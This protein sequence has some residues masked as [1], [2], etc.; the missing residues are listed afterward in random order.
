MANQHAQ[1]PEKENNERWLITYSD[2]ITLL[3]VFFIVLYSMSQQDKAK[4]E[5]IAQSLK[6]ALTGS[7]NA[8]DGS[9]GKS[10]IPGN[11]G[12]LPNEP[13]NKSETAEEK[14][15]KEIKKK[16]EELAKNEGLQASISVSQEERGIVIRIVEHLLFESGSAEL[17]PKA[18]D[19]LL[20]IGKILQTNSSQYI[21]IEGHTD[22]MP[23]SNDKF[24][25]NWELSVIRST[26]VL[27]LFA[28]KANINDQ[29]LSGIGYGEFRPIADNKT[30]IGRSKN[31]RVEIVILNSKFNESESQSSE[32]NNR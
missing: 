30:E 24:P 12:A 6:G 25:S 3:L 5:E 18:K 2:L 29:L 21:R 26:N 7:A 28:D 20:S 16:V 22:N 23:I 9:P 15:M 8:M 10:M 11:P 19:I 32:F 17:T 13:E 14:K 1:E 4:Y 31:R 27:K